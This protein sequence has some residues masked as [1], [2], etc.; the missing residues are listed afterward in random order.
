MVSSRRSTCQKS[1][2]DVHVS[3]IT[4]YN[5]DRMTPNIRAG[6]DSRYEIDLRPIESNPVAEVINNENA[7]VNAKDATIQQSYSK[8][9][10]AHL[11]QQYIQQSVRSLPIKKVKLK[12]SSKNEHYC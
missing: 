8:E 3:S 12:N 7:I 2:I 1:K 5:L 4:E 10:L 11:S 9:R 6:F